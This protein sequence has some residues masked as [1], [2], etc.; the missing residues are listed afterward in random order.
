MPGGVQRHE[1]VERLARQI[2]HVRVAPLHPLLRDRPGLALEINLIPGGV[3]QFA[4]AIIA[5]EMPPG[6]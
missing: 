1:D 3:D 2:D 6:P 5:I 4:L